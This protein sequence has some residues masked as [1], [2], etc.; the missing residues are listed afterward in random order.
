MQ[1]N[2]F[3]P[4]KNVELSEVLGPDF[5]DCILVFRMLSHQKYSDIATLGTKLSEETSASG[6]RKHFL[7]IMKVLEES[8]VEGTMINQEK[9][10]IELPKEEFSN[11]FDMTT[12]LQIV[13]FLA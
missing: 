1:N 8:Y 9:E 5:K 7:K 10:I 12:Y 11:V 4:R 13:R 6:Q 3:L 2:Y